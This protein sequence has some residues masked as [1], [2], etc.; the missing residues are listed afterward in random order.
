MQRFSVKGTVNK[1]F[2]V[3]MQGSLRPS[4]SPRT[5]SE[6]N[7]NTQLFCGDLRILGILLAC[8]EMKF[9]IYIYVFIYTQYFFL[10][11][12]LKSF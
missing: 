6:S 11:E 2:V 12:N 8:S 3:P 10:L 7:T 1:S 5:L 4:I 9:H